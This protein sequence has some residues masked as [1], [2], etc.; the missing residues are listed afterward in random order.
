LTWLKR[1]S[2]ILL[3]KGIHSSFSNHQLKN[4]ETLL[5]GVSID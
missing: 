1:F 5:K 4:V 3:V 2:M